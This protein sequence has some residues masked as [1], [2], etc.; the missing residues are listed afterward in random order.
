MCRELR[1]K[2]PARLRPAQQPSRHEQRREADARRASAAERGYDA[3]WRKARL[4]H[5]AAHPLCVMCEAR[6][7]VTAATVVDHI[8]PHHGDMALFWDAVNWQSLCERC[9]NSVKQSEER[10]EAG[11][12]QNFKCDL[13]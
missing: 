8:A 3:R 10:S 13:A 6:G 5:L 2:R 12:W 7:D 11:G 9:H 4:P 1:L